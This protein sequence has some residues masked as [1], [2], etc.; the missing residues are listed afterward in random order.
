M[1][2]REKAGRALDYSLHNRFAAARNLG[3]RAPR[4]PG[5]AE[6]R[7]C[8][9]MRRWR[10]PSMKYTQ[11]ETEFE[12]ASRPGVPAVASGNSSAAGLAVFGSVPKDGQGLEERLGLEFADALPCFGSGALLCLRVFD[13]GNLF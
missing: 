11:Q 7:D 10:I 4:A 2:C 9:A 5:D 3:D 6:G 13:L 1:A 8:P 12:V